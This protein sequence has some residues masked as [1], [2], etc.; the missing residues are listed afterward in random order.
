[1]S[2]M[3][4]HDSALNASRYTEYSFKCLALALQLLFFYLIDPG[5]DI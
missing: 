3:H 4:G 2:I 5:V 1:M